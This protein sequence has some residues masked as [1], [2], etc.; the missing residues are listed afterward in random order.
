MAAE[1]KLQTKI[2]KDLE[3]DGWL[4]NKIK[5]CTKTGWP[6]LEALKQTDYGGLLVNHSFYLEVKAKNKKLKPLQEYM[7][8]KI[9][10]HGGTVYVFDSWEAYREKFYPND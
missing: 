3:K 1:S 10:K 9:R 4:V 7:H 8:D 6:D 2:I 5:L